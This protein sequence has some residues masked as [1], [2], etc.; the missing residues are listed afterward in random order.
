[1]AEDESDFRPPD[2][3]PE[4]IRH[5]RALGPAP[6]VPR[7]RRRRHDRAAALVRAGHGRDAP[8]ALRRG[9]RGARPRARGVVVVRGDAALAQLGRRLGRRH[10]PLRV[11]RLRDPHRRARLE[12]RRPGRRLRV[13]RH[14]RAPDRSGSRGHADPHG[15]SQRAGAHTRARSRGPHDDGRASSRLRPARPGG[16]PGGGTGGPTADRDLPVAIGVGV[17]LAV[18][19]LVLFSIGPGAAMGLVTL[20]IAAAAAEFY[21][22]M[23]KVAY[24]PATLLGIVACAG[25]P[26]ATYWRGVAAMPLVLMLERRLRPAV[27]PVRRRG[28]APGPEPR[29]DAARRRLRRASRVVCRSAPAVPER[30]RH[31]ARRDHRHRRVRHRRSVRRVERGAFTPRAERQSEQDLRRPRRR[32]A[33]GDPR[34]GGHLW[35]LRAVG[36]PRRLDQAR[37]RRRDRGAARRPRASR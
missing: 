18:V 17:A 25:L 3:D 15:D 19:A 5:R 4:G 37:H 33:H 14:D 20:V 16:G 9:A 22:A 8:D 29:G 7:A 10:R 12:P 34:G 32:H 24:R 13:R 30:R 28:R 27:V 21:A 23:Q 26:L 35:P 6:A 36:Q 2:D 31:V 11:R 1:M